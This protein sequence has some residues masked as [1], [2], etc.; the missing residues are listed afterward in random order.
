MTAQMK[1]FIPKA[2]LLTGILAL[3]ACG[4]GGSG[5]SNS[6]SSA[7]A[8]SNGGS[9]TFLA[10]QVADGYLDKA[11]VFL[12]LNGNKVLDA[13]EPETNT[14]PGGHFKLQGQAA[15]ADTYAVGAQI[16][17]GHTLHDDSRPRPPHQI[18]GRHRHR[19]RRGRRHAADDL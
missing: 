15:D 10:G 3:S 1:S 9:K 16:H 19:G 18:P 17:P 8:M 6:S 11:V 5:T 2:L 12:D 7:D 14:G 4:G 13:G